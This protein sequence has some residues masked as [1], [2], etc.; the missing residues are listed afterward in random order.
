MIFLFLL[1]DV[2]GGTVVH[3]VVVELE[4]M[5]VSGVFECLL[6]W[7]CSGFELVFVAGDV[8]CS[9]IYGGWYRLDD[10]S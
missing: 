9:L 1:A 5:V 10:V 7:W 2:V 6:V 3:V 4:G 8:G